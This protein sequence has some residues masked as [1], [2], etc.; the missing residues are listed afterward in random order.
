MYILGTT[1]VFQA[2]F[3]SVALGIA[4][5]ML[6][7]IVD[8]SITKTPRGMSGPLRDQ[9]FFQ[10]QLGQ[11]EAT[12]RSAR[13]LLRQTIDE[14]WREASVNRRF[15]MKQRVDLRLASTHAIRCPLTWSTVPTTLPGQRNLREQ[16]LRRRFRDMHAVTQQVQA[17]RTITNPRAGSSSASNPTR[18]FL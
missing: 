13:A 7:A 1:N 16:P 2:G 12:L 8:M 5:A 17:G 11:S 15:E 10:S 4:R 9:S 6:D 3:A 14:V 18:S